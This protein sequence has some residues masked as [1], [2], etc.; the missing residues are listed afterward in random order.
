M[1]IFPQI[2]ILT[3][4]SGYIFEYKLEQAS[5]PGQA[6]FVTYYKIWVEGSNLRR[7]IGN[8]ISTYIDL[9]KRKRYEVNHLNTTVR[10]V[11]FEADPEDVVF[12][13]AW[14]PVERKGA[15]S[16]DV[17]QTRMTQPDGII[18]LTIWISKTSQTDEGK[19]LLELLTNQA[20]EKAFGG[21]VPKGIPVSFSVKVFQPDGKKELGFMS[22]DLVSNKKTAI[23]SEVFEMPLGYKTQ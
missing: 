7:D 22:I 11:P 21:T 20:L 8:E 19:S 1:M 6:G 9:D 15:H 18:E 17:Y 3:V 5:Q 23:P 13:K 10:E 12:T 14:P 4:W 16:C 2:L